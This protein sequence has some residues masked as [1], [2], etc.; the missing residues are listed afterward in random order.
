MKNY[1]YQKKEKQSVGGFTLLIAVLLTS[2]LLAIGYSLITFAVKQTIISTSGKESVL[3]FYAADAGAECASY[4]DLQYPGA[5]GVTSLFATTSPRSAQ[6][7]TSGFYC[8]GTDIVSVDSPKN[9]VVHSHI[10]GAIR[11]T[12]TF[13]FKLDPEPSCVQVTIA[14]W[15]STTTIESRGYNTG[16]VSLVLDSQ[17][18]QELPSCTGTP[19]PRRI[20][21]ALR[22]RY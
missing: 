19:N 4:W 5:S 21:R 14:K 3:A 15:G 17:L 12:T 11:A 13:A 6:I 10:D 1:Y 20:E 18:G 2:L 9:T 16:T 22:V 7:P 8:H